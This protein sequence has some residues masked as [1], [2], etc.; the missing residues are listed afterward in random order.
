MAL[1]ARAGVGTGAWPLPGRLLPAWSGGGTVWSCLAGA[2]AREVDG[3]RGFAFL[4]VA[5]GT[6]IGLYFA[7]THEPWL[8]AGAALA[9]LLGGLACLARERPGLFH[10]LALMTAVAAGFGVAT[11]QVARMAHPVLP[12]AYEM[13]GVSGF[14]ERSEQRPKGGRIVLRVTALERAEVW[15]VRVRIAITGAAPPPV[16]SHVLLRATL[17]PPGGPAYPGGYDFG[18]D[19][20]FDGI[21]ATGFS[22]GR[23][24]VT[25]PPEPPDLALRLRVAVDAVRQAMDARIRAALPGSTGAIATALVTGTRDAVPASVEEAMRISGIYHV[26]SISGLHMALVVAALFWGSRALLAAVPG[27]A[28]RVPIKAWAAVPAIAGASFYLLLSGAE[29]ATQRSYLMAVLVL[30][31][32]MLGRAAVT[33]R[34]LALAALVVLVLSPAALLDPGTQMS[35]AATLALVAGHER[36]AGAI[37]RLGGTQPAGKALR[38][39]VGILISSLVAALATAPYAAYHF[40]RVAPLSLI[41]NLLTAPV[42]SFVIMPAGLFGALLIPFGLDAWMFRIMGWGIDVMVRIAAKVAAIPGADGGLPAFS[43]ASLV[44]MTLGLIALCVLRSR[45]LLAGPALLAAGLFLAMTTRPPDIF[46]DADG[47]TVGVRG[48]DG[49][50]ALIGDRPAAT[51]ANRFAVT[52]W[53]AS[54]GERPTSATVQGGTA[55]PA[56]GAANTSCDPL[57]CALPLPHGGRIAYP[58]RREALIDDC[59]LAR[60]IV[61]SFTPPPDC[62]ATVIP[63]QKGSRQGALAFWVDAV[64]SDTVPSDTVQADALQE[65]RAQAD[66]GS[67]N[68]HAEDAALS[69]SMSD[70][71]GLSPLPTEPA[72]APAIQIVMA[73]PDTYQRPW[74]PQPPLRAPAP[75]SSEDT[76][77]Q[78][79]TS[80]IEP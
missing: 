76:A 20:W 69:N 10:A 65:A 53:R 38:W 51:L 61:T 60:I 27:L 8:I 33:L 19:A 66:D 2:L 44:L 9:L 32:V 5:F 62:A 34:T 26:L 28:L 23:V 70:A 50:L 43:A 16:G 3:R 54:L 52:Q 29:V 63:T 41:A 64:Q 59:R 67:G 21:G 22:V 56:S 11:L 45:L 68:I 25:E 1:A 79:E 74:L 72:P 6:G 17:A 57:G 55:S 30:A 31:G 48:P 13:I 37:Y 75:A 4:P 15:P 12:R 7:A 80:T 40:H 71:S 73:R 24:Q 14:V 78:T 47:T 49:R 18:R 77:G 36:F 35:F 58:L 39:V 46:I 42:I